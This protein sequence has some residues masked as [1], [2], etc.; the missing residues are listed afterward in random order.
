MIFWDN[1]LGI[2]LVKVTISKQWCVSLR[3]IYVM[4]LYEFS[5]CIPPYHITHVMWWW[6]RRYNRKNDELMKN[7]LNCN[8]L[9]KIICED[10][11]KFIYSLVQDLIVVCYFIVFGFSFGLV[12]SFAT[13][14]P[15]AKW[16]WPVL[17]TLNYNKNGRLTSFVHFF[18][19][20]RLLLAE[21]EILLHE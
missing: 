13:K 6:W 9:W 20:F 10:S 3:S 15:L 16:C 19:I 18:G 17:V 5:V 21:I 1:Y 8:I 11:Q 7:I 4:E 14:C 12:G 2:A